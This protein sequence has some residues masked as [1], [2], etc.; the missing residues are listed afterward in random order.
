MVK[1]K[2]III[3][4]IVAAVL[5]L[6]VAGVFIFANINQKPN[7]SFIGI[8]QDKNDSNTYWTVSENKLVKETVSKYTNRRAAYTISLNEEEKTFSQLADGNVKA[9]YSYTIDESGKNIEITEINTAV[10]HEDNAQKNGKD[11]V[12]RMQRADNVNKGEIPLLD[13]FKKDN[14]LV[15]TWANEELGF[16][17]TF[18]NN[19]YVTTKSG[20]DGNAE[21]K[22][23]YAYD[24]D[25]LVIKNASGKESKI[26]I[27]VGD[28]V[29]RI[30]GT[31]F[32]K[33]GE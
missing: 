24:G 1:K 27:E 7:M 22:C 21:F 23:A 19:G 30:N 17:Y 15:G 8:W 20:A 18:D 5:A 2:K 33:R 13:S 9:T 4:V 29:I 11:T 14:N 25:K 10:N 28:N 26:N 6:I 12:T 3:T 16:V 32:N 31:L